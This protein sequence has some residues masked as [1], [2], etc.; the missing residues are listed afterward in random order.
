MSYTEI[1]ELGKKHLAELF[2]AGQFDEETKRRML[3]A[4]AQGFF[5]GELKQITKRINEL[6]S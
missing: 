3:V 1:Q 4:F 2:E 6:Q 5:A